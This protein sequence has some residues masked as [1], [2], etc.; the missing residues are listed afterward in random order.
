MKREEDLEV[1]PLPSNVKLEDITRE[2]NEHF[3]NKDDD[4]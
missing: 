1:E 4:S 2:L 3:N